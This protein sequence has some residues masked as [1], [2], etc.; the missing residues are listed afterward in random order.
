MG[1]GHGQPEPGGVP[2][3]PSRPDE[4]GRHERLA[5]PGCQG[6]PGA[7][8]HGEEDRGQDDQRRQLGAAEQVGDVA[9]ASRHHGRRNGRR[10]A[11]RDRRRRRRS[12][13]SG[14]ARGRGGDR[15]AA[16]RRRIG[17]REGRGPGA[18][19][20][21]GEDDAGDIEG[22]GQPIL[23]ISGQPARDVDI[24]RGGVAGDRL[25]PLAVPDDHHLAPADPL[26]VRAVL[27]GD[28]GGAEAARHLRAPLAHDPHGRHAARPG[29][30]L[31]AGGMQFQVHRPAARVEVQLAAQVEARRLAGRIGLAIGHFA[32]PVGV[33]RQSLLERRDLGEVDDHVHVD[34]VGLDPQRGVVVD[35][36]V[37]ERMSRRDRRPRPADR[38]GG[39]DGEGDRPDGG[40]S[41]GDE[42][43]RRVARRI[44]RRCPRSSAARGGGL[45]ASATLPR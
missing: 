14:R 41:H 15:G 42:G 45:R 27:E 33:D 21:D 31:Q 16:D 25:D 1:D 18:W 4:I 23:G 24:G 29:G 44:N 8:G 3:R 11:G 36:E 12:R 2:D 13:R 32:V 17:C 34:R 26:R 38:G 20:A 22:L 39:E 37:P 30:E 6:V 10:C 43:T 7:Q 35:R 28:G 9:H 40:G 5:V 19:S